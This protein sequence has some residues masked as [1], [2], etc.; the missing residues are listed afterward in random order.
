ML[1]Y[2][3]VDGATGLTRAQARTWEQTL[4]NKYGFQKEGGQL[5]NQINSIQPKNWLD[6]LL[7]SQ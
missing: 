5:L 3:V 2:Q 4:I 6:Y 7:K 1:R